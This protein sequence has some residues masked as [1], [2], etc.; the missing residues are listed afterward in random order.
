MSHRTSTASS[1]TVMSVLHLAEGLMASSAGGMT[2]LLLNG[3]HIPSPNVQVNLQRGKEGVLDMS[4]FKACQLSKDSIDTKSSRRFMQRRS[5]M[6][7]LTEQVMLCFIRSVSI[8]GILVSIKLISNIRLLVSDP[9]CIYLK[10][11]NRPSVF[12]T[13]LSHPQAYIC[14]DSFNGMFQLRN[15]VGTRVK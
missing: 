6:E 14:S 5:G 15:K 11:N 4:H 8:E 7:A 10:Y 9:I 2:K 12:K 3:S 13:S 1:M